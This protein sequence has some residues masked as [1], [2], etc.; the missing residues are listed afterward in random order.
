[1]F[2]TRVLAIGAAGTGAKAWTLQSGWQIAGIRVDNKSGSWLLLNDG[3]FVPP[4]TIN[5]GHSFQPTIA[6]IDVMFSNGPAGQVSTQQGDKPVVM[7]YSE[8][9]GESPGVP[10]G[11]GTSFIEQFT[12]VVIASD[13]QTVTFSVGITARVLIAATA[14]KRIRVLT[15]NCTM[16]PFASNPPVSW[17]TGMTLRFFQNT[18]GVDQVALVRL[19]PFHPVDSQLFPSGLDCAVGSPLKYSAFTDF[20]TLPVGIMVTHQ[21]I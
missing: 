2:D 13:Q 4:Y 21:L 20:F 1:M 7:I 10:S 9:V 8:P 6:S 12:P 17:D 15:I 11:Q 5:F 3:T 18:D 14:N 16:V 19:D